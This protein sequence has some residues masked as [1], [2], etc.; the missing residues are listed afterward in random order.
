MTDGQGRVVNFSNTIIIM[1]SN[2]KNENA[3][4]KHFL[5][6]FINRIDEMIFFNVLTIKEMPEIVKVQI[7]KL[8]R[9]LLTERRITLS[10]SDKAIEW[11]AY[12]GFDMEYGARPL[13]RFIMKALE[14]PLAEKILSGQIAD[15]GFVVVDVS[16]KELVIK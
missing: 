3:V 9:R 4:R 14:D 10:V 7:R 1:T 11:L 15:G 2:L 8:E 16:G 5:P 6:E 12:N 13:R